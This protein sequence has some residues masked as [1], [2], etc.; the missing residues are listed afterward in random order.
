[1]AALSE[2]LQAAGIDP[3]QAKCSYWEE[4][5]TYPGANYT[6]KC[7]TVQIGNTKEDFDASATL[8]SPSVTVNTMKQLM[9][10]VNS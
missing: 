7:I 4:L 5:V 6:N 1:M 10:V 9:G 2:A 8:K 3:S